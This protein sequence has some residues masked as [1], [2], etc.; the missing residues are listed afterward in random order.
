MGIRKRRAE[1]TGTPA[2]NQAKKTESNVENYSK[3]HRI[4]GTHSRTGNLM[5]VMAGQKAQG[6]NGKHTMKCN[7]G[8]REVVKIF[9]S[10]VTYAETRKDGKGRQKTVNLKMTKKFRKP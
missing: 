8:P 9:K 1:I 4:G 7:K 10:R 2:V 3:R 5:L 6:T